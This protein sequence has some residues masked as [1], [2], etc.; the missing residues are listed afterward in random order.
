MKRLTG[1]DAITCRYLYRDFFSYTPTFKIVFATNEVPRFTSQGY[2]MRRRV[3]ILPFSRT[4]Y[5]AGD[6]KTPIRDEHL[7]EKLRAELPGILAWAVRG[8]LN[9]QRQGLRPPT[10]VMEET[11][12]LFESFDSLAD[13]LDEK[14]VKLPKAQVETGALWK[15]YLTWCEENERQSAY[16]QPQGFSRNLAQRDGISTARRHDGRYLLGIG[17]KA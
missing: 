5:P 13:F 6:E 17:L 3:H 10:R 12:E 2:A 15:A 8:C 1:G 9:W 14:C 4:F 16:R 7:R 11:R